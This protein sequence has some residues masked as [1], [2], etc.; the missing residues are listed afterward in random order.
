MPAAKKPTSEHKRLTA[1]HELDILDTQN[2]KVFD[3]IVTNAASV[4]DKPIAL[5][6]LVDEDRQ[7]FKASY[8]LEGVT[9]TNRD[10][11]FCAHT[12]LDEGILQVE[13]AIK[14]PRFADNPLVLSDPNIRFYAG[15]PLSLTNGHHVGTLCVIDSQPG[16]LTQEQEN[17]L[18]ALGKST[19]KALESRKHARLQTKQ[20]TLASNAMAV[21]EHSLDPI[22]SLDL[23]GRITQWN[24]AAARLFGYTQQ[25]ALHQHINLIIPDDHWDEEQNIQKLLHAQKQGYEYNTVRCHKDGRHIDVNINILPILDDQQQLIGATKIVKDRTQA[26]KTLHDIVSNETKFRALSESSPLGIFSIDINGACTYTNQRW[27]EIFNLSAEK[28][29]GLDWTKTIHADDQQHVIA[30]WKRCVEQQIDFDMEFRV[31]HAKPTYVHTRARVT[32]D[33]HNQISGYIGSVEDISLRFENER[34]ILEQKLQTQQIIQNQSVATFMIDANHRVLHW[35]I[36]CENLTGVKAED[37]IGTTEAWRGFYPKPRPCLADLVVDHHKDRAGQFYP[38]QGESTLTESGWHAENWF[39]NLGGKKRYVIFD[40]APIYDSTGEI[41][42]AIE[43]LQDVTDQQ[44]SAQALAAKEQLLNRTGEVAGVG[45]WE[46]DLIEHKLTWSDETCKIHKV[47]VGYQPTV[48]E[49]LKFYPPIARN[50]IQEAIDKAA[51][52]G[53]PWDLELPFIQK[54]G[55]QIWVR[56][57]GTAER[58]DGKTTKLYGAIQNI[59]ELVQQRQSI[60]E[61]NLRINLATHS[62]RIGIWD[63]KITSN[64]VIWDDS[65]YALY[66]LTPQTKP[67]D[68]DTWVNFIHPDDVKSF[69]KALE[70]F[71]SQARE[72]DTAYRIIW[73]DKSIHYI[74]LTAQNKVDQDGKV[75]NVVGACWDVTEMREMSNK[76]A[77]QNEYMHVT[78]QSIADAVITTDAHGDV[79]WL[80]PVAE[81]LTGWLKSEAVGK[82]IEQV[83][84]ILDRTQKSQNKHPVLNCLNNDGAPNQSESAVLISKDSVEYGIEDSI[85]PIRSSNNQILGT[86][87]VFRDVTEKRKITE[88]IEY[89]ASHDLLTNLVNRSEFEARLTRLLEKTRTSKTNHAL[90]LIDLD[91][92]K[93]VNDA[94]GHAAGDQLLIE[95][96]NIFSNVIR[97][98]DTLARL[99]GDEFGIILEKCTVDQAQKVAQKI[100]DRVH[101]FRFIHDNKRYRIGSSIGLIPLDQRWANISQAIQTADACC[102]AAKDEGRNRV[103]R[104]LESDIIIKQRQGDLHWAARIEQA[105]EQDQFSLYAQRIHSNKHDNDDLHA[106]ILLRLIDDD[107]NMIAPN[108][109]IPAAERYHLISR[110]DLW[111]IQK[112]IQWIANN[113]S[114][115]PIGMIHINISG[116]SISDRSFHQSVEKLLSNTKASIR[117]LLCLEITETAAIS[118]LSDASQFINQL[119]ALDVKVALDDFGAG[120]SSFGY[121][122][123]MNVDMLKIDGQFIKNIGSDKLNDSAVRCFTDIASILGLETVAE[124]VE[125]QESLD[126]IKALGV[127][128]GQGFLI[129]KPCPIDEIFHHS[130]V[131]N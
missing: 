24:P 130:P 108:V 91:Q 44:K 125:N 13:D 49:A 103:H 31:G 124:F 7:W 29:L 66:G 102:Y 53:E 64:E 60:E 86:V 40:A 38:V 110:L 39:N 79:T 14:D 99:G 34:S 48:E 116:D 26:L 45:G 115:A 106:E 109:F 117:K 57:V 4:C 51:S 56:A 42:A 129:H 30:E 81:R 58:K 127:D 27:Q 22:I 12:I 122:R 50:I 59:S 107:G 100:C 105:M 92:F 16:K 17:E 93:L 121:L 118:R 25:K 69:E 89:K 63:W 23:A 83:F 2:E 62:G 96:S 94:C 90:M 73:A 82:P 113:Q 61:S 11:A 41:V 84:I 98:R 9:E 101:E 112:A 68:Y 75:I 21:V 126:H 71:I 80:N 8:G 32:F 85:A 47:P 114:N 77:E 54:G 3:D 55:T 111:V 10:A 78:M 36:A 128:Y 46:Y 37:I 131:N 6:S 119:H 15:T 43:T 28:S 18:K 33:E 52:S 76:L 123:S 87:V 1:L 74:R 95:V 5:I 65:M 88:E 20:Q 19:V 104:W 67:I 35:N 97:T 70:K 120:A 72:I